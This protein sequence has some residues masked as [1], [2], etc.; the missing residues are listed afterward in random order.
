MGSPVPI[1][2]VRNV[3]KSFV[4]SKRI[5]GTLTALENVDL[6]VSKGEFVSLVG[7]SGCGKTTLLRMMAGL[8]ECD[9]G[10]VWLRGARVEGVP[11]RIGFVFQQPALLPWRT[12]YSNIAFALKSQGLSAEEVENNIM[13][14]LSLTGL[15]SFA[16]HY[17]RM[18]SGG[19]Q[20]RVGLARALAGGPDVMLMDEPLSALDALT[21]R[22]IQ[23]E[24]SD[25]ISR[26]GSTAVLVTHEVE[27]AVYFSDRIIILGSRPGHIREIVPVGLARPRVRATIS[28]EPEFGRLVSYVLGVI[29]DNGG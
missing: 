27:E 26:A 16:E 18:L 20:Q 24:I 15:G 25:I 10:E 23:Q 2:D 28:A 14:S 8:V 7:T 12:V 4:L 21:R 9:R 19:M 11:E 5:G 13:D 29:F 3:T 22:Q 17:P 1:I 6:T